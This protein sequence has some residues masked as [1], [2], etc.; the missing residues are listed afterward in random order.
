[1]GLNLL[2]LR[3]L[4][5]NLTLC[6]RAGAVVIAG[7]ASLRKLGVNNLP[8]K[9]PPGSGLPEGAVASSYTS[10]LR[11]GEYMVRPPLCS[12]STDRYLSSDS[13]IATAAPLLS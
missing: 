6:T 5:S 13:V 7:G 3:L 4:T 12:S 1:M 8:P 10:A 2:S 9:V 11:Q